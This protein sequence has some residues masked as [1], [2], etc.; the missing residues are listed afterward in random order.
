MKKI[1]VSALLLS[2]MFGCNSILDKE[3][4][5][6]ITASNYYKTGDDAESAITGAYDA[7]QGD[8]YYGSTMNIIGEMPS[9][10]C[11]SNNGDVVYLDRITWNATSGIVGRI[12]QMAFQGINRANSILKYVPGI[13]MDKTRQEQILGE[14]YFIRALNYFNLVKL[15]GGVPLRTEPVESGE[16]PSL[17]ASTAEQIYAQIEADLTK[18]EEMAATQQG[19]N[20]NDPRNRGRAIKTTVNALQARVYLT[21][22]KWAQAVEA[23]NKVITSGKYGNTLTPNFNDLWPANNKTESI[24]EIEYAG[25]EDGGFTLPDLTLPLPPAT[26]SFPKYNIPTNE[27]V[28]YADTAKDNRFKYNGV[29]SG[30]KSYGSMVY[31]GAGTGNDNGW[32]VYKWRNT[33]FFNSSDNYPVLR[34]AEMYLIYAE[35]MN[36]QGGPSQDALDKLNAVCTRAGLTALT[37]TDLATK[38]AFRDEVD[39]QRRLELAFEGERWFDLLRYAAHTKADPSAEHQVT[40]LDIIKAVRG[41]EDEHYLLFPIPQYELNNNPS[42]KQNTGY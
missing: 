8:T 3:P 41:T 6:S 16:S 20:N 31:G 30:G 10:N 22:R 11:T 37:L 13:A 1:F 18:A 7:F 42:I 15:Y 5:T 19:G 29:V 28:Q 26:Y 9:D 14:A 35:A 39:R 32:F 40:A 25:T 4:L 12:Y 38:Q 21:E 2:G 34:L 27:F 33:N 17:A 23:A 24:F 36:E